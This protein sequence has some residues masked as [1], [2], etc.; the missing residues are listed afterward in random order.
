MCVSSVSSFLLPWP[1]RDEPL[2]ELKAA[3][4]TIEAALPLGCMYD[5]PDEK[6]KASKLRRDEL[7]MWIKKV[8]S[9]TNATQ[10]RRMSCGRESA[11]WLKAQLIHLMMA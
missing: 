4:L 10:V 9:A 5:V 3:L 6:V 7:P 1:Q 8:E 11:M 2:Y